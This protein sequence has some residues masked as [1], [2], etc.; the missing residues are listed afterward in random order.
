MQLN[1]KHKNILITGA[2]RGIGKS[3]AEVLVSSGA[4][5]ALQYN[6]NSNRA[7]KVK[8]ELGSKA[9]LYQC[10]FSAGLDVSSFFNKV[11]KDL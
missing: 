11:L 4:N 6:Q 10:D 3:I 9:K 1:L 5:V 8:K 7:E 2:S